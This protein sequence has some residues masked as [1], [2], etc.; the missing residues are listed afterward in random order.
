MNGWVGKIQKLGE[1]V[2]RE[3]VMGGMQSEAVFM[4]FE[5][6]MAKEKVMLCVGKSEIKVAGDE[7]LRRD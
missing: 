6:K 5:V 3:W 4:E 1:M 7:I 2:T